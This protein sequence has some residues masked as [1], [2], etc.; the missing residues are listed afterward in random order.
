MIRVLITG[1]GGQ[2]GQCIGSLAEDYKGLKIHFLTR[3]EL[4]IVDF[5]RVRVLLQ[6]QGFDY[7]INAAAFTPVDLAEK[8]KE[9]AFSINATAA[10]NLAKACVGTKTVLIHISTDYVFD[11]SAQRPYLET[12]IPAPINV[13]GASKWE[14]EKQIRAAHSRHYI[15]RTSWLYSQFG[16]N[17]YKTIL[18]MAHERKELHVTDSEKGSPT[19]AADLSHFVL[20]ICAGRF[21][22]PFGTYHF[23]NTGISS[24][25]EFASEILKITPDYP[26]AKLLRSNNYVTFAKRPKYSV[27]STAKT[28]SQFKVVLPEWRESLHHIR[29]GAFV[30]TN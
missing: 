12:D 5:E 14:G 1:A 15:I 4:D 6:D 7:C 11:G 19:H 20:G 9:R 2:L 18:Q 10:G 28:Q 26:S 13:Y 23:C 22:A 3:D 24:R 30:L 17:F 27:L 21:K 8:Q 25:F 16:D 29:T